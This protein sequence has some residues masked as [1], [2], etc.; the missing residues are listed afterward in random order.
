MPNEVTVV[1]DGDLWSALPADFKPLPTTQITASGAAPPS[2]G[3]HAPGGVPDAVPPEIPWTKAM[4]EAAWAIWTAAPIY[5]GERRL[6]ALYR[7]ARALEPKADDLE[8]W[9]LVGFWR[10]RAEDYRQQRDDAKA[11]ARDTV[12]EYQRLADHHLTQ[13]LIWEER[14]RRA[15]ERCASADRAVGRAIKGYR[16]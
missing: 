8:E 5:P 6:E 12:I 15:E 11:A 7:A 3:Q 13:R 1:G 9:G 2:A 16:P 14:A 10:G 4:E